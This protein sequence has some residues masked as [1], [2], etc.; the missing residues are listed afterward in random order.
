MFFVKAYLRDSY[1]F[2]PFVKDLFKG[3]LCLFN[4][5]EGKSI[6]VEGFTFMV[7]RIPRAVKRSPAPRGFLG[8]VP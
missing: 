7:P 6:L 5:L 4:G 8:Y 1:L 3:L 2:N